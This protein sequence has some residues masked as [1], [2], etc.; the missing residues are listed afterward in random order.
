MV[1]ESYIKFSGQVIFLHS[2]EN[3]YLFLKK[4]QAKKVDLV[5]NSPVIFWSDSDDCNRSFLF[6]NQLGL[7]NG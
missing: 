2:L 5:T 6:A 4:H 3:T 1:Y 7:D